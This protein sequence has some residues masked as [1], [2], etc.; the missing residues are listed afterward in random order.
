[1][2]YSGFFFSYNNFYFILACLSFRV[3]NLTTQPFFAK[4]I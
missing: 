2:K 3:T 4:K 1:M